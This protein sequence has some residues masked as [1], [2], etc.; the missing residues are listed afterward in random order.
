MIYHFNAES[1]FREAIRSAGLIPPDVIEPGMFH[2]FPGEGKGNR[3]TAAWCKMFPDGMGGIFGDYS[4]GLSDGWQAKREK[5]FSAS[6][7]EAFKR[8][9]AEA[10]KQ[11]EADQ[12]ERQAEAAGK[13]AAV[14][15]AALPAPKDHPYLTRKGIKAGGA[16]LHKDAL[17]IPMRAGGEMHSLQFIGADGEKRFLT[18]GR[19]TGCYFSIGNLKG[20]TALCIAEG[21]AT[22]ATIHEATGYPV[23]VA[24]NAG[25][26]GPVAKAMRERFA[27]L[28]LILC[29]DDD[30]RTDG[31]PGLTKATE[32]ARSVGGKLAIP[33]FG[34]DR[35]EKA[36]DFNDMAKL[37]GAEAV[38]RAI[39]DAKEVKGSLH[40]TTA[41]EPLAAAR[42]GTLPDPSHDKISEL[43]KLSPIEYD[44]CREKAAK[45][46]GIRAST[47]DAEVTKARPSSESD[48]ASGSAMLFDEPE[49][50]P[51]PVDGDELLNDLTEVFKR[52]V[53]LPESAALALS[54]WVLHSHAHDAARVSPILCLSSPEKR[55]GKTTALTLLQALV[56][57]PLPASNITSAALFRATEL[58]RPTLLIDE[59]DTFLRD[60]DEL[61]GVIN[62]GHTRDAAYVIRTVGED[63]EPRAF[64]TWAPKAIALIGRLPPT[65]TD[66]AIIIALRR[67]LPGEKV[68]RLR[69]DRTAAFKDFPRRCARW[70]ADNFTELE[71]SDPKTP[72]GLH[73]RAADNWRPLLAIAEAAGG[74]WP[75]LARAAIQA[76]TDSDE[77]DDAAGVMLLEDLRKLFAKS[78]Q[79]AS[80]DLAEKLG[81]MEDRPWPEW[82]QG[83]PITTRQVARLLKPFGIH[84]K[85]LRQEDDR[86][87]KG[88]EKTE[89][90][91]AFSRYLPIRSA[92]PLQPSCDAAL[93]NFR[94]ATGENNVADEKTLEPA[95]G[96]QCSGVADQKEEPWRVRL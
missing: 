86:I 10:R 92:T 74:E 76:L 94:S 22:G 23:V 96:R 37:Y 26:L 15:E 64:C 47:L 83:K 45:E 72:V 89:F 91:D 58:W 71:K 11:A 68:E 85:N 2:K 43:A 4:T 53:I 12:K 34:T 18:G 65:L 79:L 54:L 16:R 93:R 61:R 90:E 69:L 59:A 36:T 78:D 7:R 87:L 57:K 75:G 3:N 33:D 31:N 5:P 52:H 80:V 84:P 28:P 8:H 66:R 81:G 44:K 14:W 24:F 42:L 46:L 13:A 73:D 88:Y 1:E 56:R 9:V 77:G 21:F 40:E 20:A 70:V 27:E 25:N 38:G 6:E 62:S 51:D 82:K 30:N 39:A 49:P 63:H 17:V 95:L 55:C 67:K 48:S 50:W 60:S 29:A 19:V 35:P 41:P 32:A